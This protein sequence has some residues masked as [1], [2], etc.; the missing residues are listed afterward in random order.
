MK[1]ATL[2]LLVI[3]SAAIL[4]APL[5]VGAGWFNKSKD[6]SDSEQMETPRYDNY[7]NMDFHLGTLTSSG[8]SDWSLGELNVQLS[9]NCIIVGN[10][11]GTA[12]MTEG[13]QAI[14]TGSRIG[15]TI[16]AMRVT[17]LKANWDMG[18]KNYDEE[19]IW[20]DSD[21]SVG[22]GHGPS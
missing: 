22:V 2:F 12:E 7:P 21:P 13:R 20:S 15:N 16:G 10:D 8:F 17:I 3:G 6:K 18:P 14:I 4:L 1:R 11:G 9:P 5:D 19:V